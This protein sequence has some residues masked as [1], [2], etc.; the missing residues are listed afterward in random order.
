M[1]AILRQGSWLKFKFI[2]KIQRAK[3]E[4]KSGEKI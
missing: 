3:R 1:I 4:Y 2:V